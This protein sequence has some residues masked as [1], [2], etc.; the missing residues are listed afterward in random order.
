MRPFI[1]PKLPLSRLKW[2]TL[3]PH[4]SAAALEVGRYDG[5]LQGML[6]P[7]LLLSP[8]E[9]QEAELS[10]RIEGTQATLEEVLEY[11]AHPTRKT[12]RYDDIEEVLNYRQAMALATAA[13]RERPLSLNMI[14]KMHRVLLQGVR[15]Q[16]RSP[17]EFRTVQVLVGGAGATLETAS[18]VPPEPQH[19]LA[20]LDNW[21]RYLHMQE[22]DVLIQTALMHAQFELIHPFLDGNG[23]VGRILIPLFLYEKGVL[24]S[25]SLYVSAYF[26]RNRSAYYAHLRALATENAWE[27]WIVFFLDA[28]KTQARENSRQVR[29]I[30]AL[31]DA[32]KQQIVAHVRSS[33]ALPILDHIFRQPIFSVPQMTA[34][35]HIAP[36]TVSRLV[37]RLVALGL[38]QVRVPGHTRRAATYACEELLRIVEGE[39]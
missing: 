9:R 32:M 3:L 27:A 39:R 22:R 36:Q 31:Y 16:F 15:G 2:E 34:S 11:E 12:P 26:E 5:L 18:Y 29:Q 7:N 14:R 1:P 8:L 35:L 28:L 23:R 10:S 25:P 13:L 19:V 33:Y 4:S 38:V 21:E 6:N 37:K 17:G 24:A 20:L 30:N